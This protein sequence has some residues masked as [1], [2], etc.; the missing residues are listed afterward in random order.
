MCLL[1]S[2]SQF[3]IKLCELTDKN[4]SEYPKTIIG[5]GVSIESNLN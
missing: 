3:D 5:K 2:E 4:L 1:M